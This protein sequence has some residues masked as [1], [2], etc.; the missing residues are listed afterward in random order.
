MAPHSS[1]SSD[2][3]GADRSDTDDDSGSGGGL[4][5]GEDLDALESEALAQSQTSKPKHEY[6]DDDFDDKEAELI[7]SQLPERKDELKRVRFGADCEDGGPLHLGDGDLAKPE[8]EFDD[9][10]AELILSQV[11]EDEYDD[12]HIESEEN[13]ADNSLLQGDSDLVKLARRALKNN[14]GFDTFRHEQEAAIVSVLAGN[15]T[16]VIFPTGG[17]KSLCYQVSDSMERALSPVL[18]SGII[19]TDKSDQIPAL[20]FTELD[21]GRKTKRNGS[22]ITIVVSPLIALMKDQV[23]G[24]KSRNISADC[25]DSTKSWEQVQ[26]IYNSI[27][28]GSLDILYCAPERLS[29]EKFIEILKCVH[30]GIRLLAVDEAHC[31][32]E[33]SPVIMSSRFVTRLSSGVD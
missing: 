30:G 25:I 4:F 21:Q 13:A 3:S 1:V 6:S 16:L 14:F 9:D 33:V 8:L 12:K 18:K 24:L 17:G 15:N 11:Q 29:N 22:G 32:S 19:S 20:A 26:H 2:S 27:H 23:D 31:V 7:F 10:E 5:D 28:N